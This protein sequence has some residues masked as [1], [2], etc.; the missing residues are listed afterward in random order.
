MNPTLI[1]RISAAGRVRGLAAERRKHADQLR[2]AAYGSVAR[3]STGQAIPEE[4]FDPTDS[5]LAWL[6]LHSNTHWLLPRL[7]AVSLQA[8]GALMS[9]SHVQYSAHDAT[10]FDETDDLEAA[11]DPLLVE[12]QDTD[13]PAGPSTLGRTGDPMHSLPGKSLWDMPLPVALVHRTNPAVGPLFNPD[14]TAMTRITRD[15]DTSTTRI[16]RTSGY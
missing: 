3:I 1:Q 10:E 14:C 16:F 13:Q 11:D 8:N 4:H 15:M 5:S 9:G 12:R 7:G 6:G 2:T